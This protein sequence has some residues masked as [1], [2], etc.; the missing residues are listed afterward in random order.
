MT[1][2][3]SAKKKRC[4]FSKPTLLSRLDLR[5][6]KTSPVMRP[7][8]SILFI[9]RPQVLGILNIPAWRGPGWKYKDR[10][11]IF[12][13]LKSAFLCIEWYQGLVLVLL[14]LKVP[15]MVLLNIGKERT[16]TCCVSINQL[17]TKNC[18]GQDKS[19]RR[20]GR[21]AGIQLDWEFAI[22]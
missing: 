3:W 14:I 6:K 7:Y 10:V 4:Q 8:I 1:I 15:A 11:I 18:E 22:D 5:S 9:C 17:A 20:I 16:T 13:F 12:S 2:I 21:C 19:G